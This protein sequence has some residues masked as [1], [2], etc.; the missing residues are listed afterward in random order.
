VRRSR[1][2]LTFAANYVFSKSIDNASSPENGDLVPGPNGPTN[3]FNGLIYT[4]WDL[5]Q[6]RALSDFN[7][8]HNFSGSFGYALP[9]GRGQRF[10]AGHGRLI[11][12]ALGNWE[13]SG[14]VRWRSGFPLSPSDGFN[15]PTDFFLSSPGALISPLSSHV[16][17]TG[18]AVNFI[19][20]LFS[21]PQTA[22]AAVGP[23]L[24]GFSGSRNVLIGPAFADFDADLHKS[25][26]MPWS[27]NQR[28]QIRV[29][30]YNV[31]NSVNFS[32][33]ISLDPTLAN[34]FAQFTSTIGNRQGGARQME[35]AARFEF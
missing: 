27:E 35:F 21:N 5:H 29:S 17:R 15:F 25:F 16:T 10:G 1:G 14:L 3:A 34:T 6:N 7:V 22:I 11:N 28:L 12:A 30:A 4:P 19:P 32:D 2:N 9:F 23:V 18:M 33:G 20:N 24:P 26:L 8:K 13:V 31:F